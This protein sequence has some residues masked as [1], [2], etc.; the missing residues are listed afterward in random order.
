MTELDFDTIVCFLN[1][2]QPTDLALKAGME[3]DKAEEVLRAIVKIA[4]QKREKELAPTP[5]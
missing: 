5:N 1:G 2:V 3:L 4:H